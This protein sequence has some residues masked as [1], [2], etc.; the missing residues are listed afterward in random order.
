[1]ALIDRAE[2]INGGNFANFSSTHDEFFREDGQMVASDLL[3]AECSLLLGLALFATELE[4]SRLCRTSEKFELE[5]SIPNRSPTTHSKWL[6]EARE[7][8]P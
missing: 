8:D 2:I 6:V 5:L 3:P 1:M 4:P 7:I